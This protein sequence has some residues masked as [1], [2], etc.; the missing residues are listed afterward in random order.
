MV[1]LT[2]PRTKTSLISFTEGHA[3]SLWALLEGANV[4]NDFGVRFLEYRK[5]RF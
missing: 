5:G 2:T 3:C 1:L 4:Q